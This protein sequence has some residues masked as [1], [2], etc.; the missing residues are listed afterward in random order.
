M[1]T[2]NQL[3]S[4]QYEMAEILSLA[5]SIVRGLDPEFLMSGSLPRRLLESM[6]LFYRVYDES[7]RMYLAYIKE[8][9]G[10]E[11]SCQRGCSWC[12]YQMPSG[13]YSFEYIYIYEGLTRANPKTLY[14]ARLLDRSEHFSLIMQKGENGKNLERYVSKNLPCA[15]LNPDDNTCDLYHFR[16][17]LCRSYF[18]LGRPRYCHPGRFNPE[19]KDIIHIE[20]SGKV[21]QALMD[22]DSSLPFR[23]SPIMSFGI[24]EFGINI[25]K[26]KPIRWT[27]TS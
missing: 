25:M 1:G 12:C 16:P 3:I 9:L 26:C 2:R 14:L 4:Y 21:R 22:F 20:P 7:C 24:L 13:L 5:T 11:V 15:F 10:R 18:S 23:L 8:K 6:E 17:L 19:S 27:D